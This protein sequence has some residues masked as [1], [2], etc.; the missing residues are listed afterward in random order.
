[1]D[2]HKSESPKEQKTKTT[3]NKLAKEQMTEDPEMQHLPTE[4]KK[5]GEVEDFKKSLK[6]NDDNKHKLKTQ[7]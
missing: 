3:V 4:G 2:K 6:N 5:P 1:M 7:K